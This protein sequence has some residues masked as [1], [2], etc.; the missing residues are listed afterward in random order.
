M[1]IWEGIKRGSKA[2]AR[3]PG[4]QRYE[5]AGKTIRCLHCDG[6]RFFRGSVLMNTV[7]MSVMGLDWANKEATTLVCDACGLVHWFGVT[8]REL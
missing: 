2:F 4:P 7:G 1:G 6:E 3:G 8:P 5:A